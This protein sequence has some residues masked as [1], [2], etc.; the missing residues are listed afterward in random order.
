MKTITF[1]NQVVLATLINLLSVVVIAGL[2]YMTSFNWLS[3]VLI[4]YVIG[5][6]VLTVLFFIKFNFAFGN[7]QHIINLTRSLSIG[8]VVK[9]KAIHTTDQELKTLA[10]AS[11]AINQTYA[12]LMTLATEIGNKNFDFEFRPKS[13][14]DELSK[15]MISM[16]ESLREIAEKDAQQNWMAAGLAK[17]GDLLR[18]ENETLETI[19]FIVISN[20]CRYLNANQGGLFVYTKE[21]EEES[22]DLM[23]SFA[24]DKQKFLEKKIILKR[25]DGHYVYGEGLVGQSFIDNETIF[26]TEIP[27]EYVKI[28]SGLGQ[29]LPRNILIVPL[30]YNDIIVGVI[31]LASFNK[32]KEHEIHFVERLCIQV[33]AIIVAEN[34]NKDTR[35]LLQDASIQSE[36]LLLKENDMKKSYL[37]IAAIQEEL[38]RNENEMKQLKE[39]MEAE[40]I[41]KTEELTVLK[42]EVLKEQQKALQKE[43]QVLAI[44]NGIES[45]IF[46]STEEGEILM[47]N[48]GTSIMMGYAMKELIGMNINNFLLIEKLSMGKPFRHT[49]KQK[50]GTSLPCEIVVNKMGINGVKANMYFV[51]DISTQLSTENE[52]AHKIE[53]LETE[54]K[55]WR[56]K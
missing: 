28:T 26:M 30:Q 3:L 14:E 50:N 55:T 47:A 19:S 29:S 10:E 35:K 37:E 46:L 17:F 34:I 13:E 44:L 53:A 25:E 32:F 18:T 33:G 45:A 1:K 31:E 20:L 36:E 9:S 51:T 7:L 38:S 5:A 39:T 2:L 16:K 54:L 12:E 6:G 4:I 27:E 23:A 40:V 43:Q 11:T 42:E 41:Q 56:T 21:N 49:M 52:Y 24:Y 22:L 48:E 8:K 15:A